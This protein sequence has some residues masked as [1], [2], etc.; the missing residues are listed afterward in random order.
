VVSTSIECPS[1]GSKE[2]NEQSRRKYECSFCHSIFTYVDPKE[3]NSIATNLQVSG[4]CST[5]GDTVKLRVCFFCK[6][7]ICPN[8]SKTIEDYDFF[9]CDNCRRDGD[10]KA[11]VLAQR[12]EKEIK[13]KIRDLQRTIHKIDSNI[14]EETAYDLEKAKMFIPIKY[15]AISAGISILLFIFLIVLFGSKTIIPGII[16]IIASIVSGF[17]LGIIKTRGNEKSL[18]Q[19]MHNLNKKSYNSKLNQLHAMLESN[20]NERLK[21]RNTLQDIIVLK[22]ISSDN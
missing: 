14:N 17:M 21:E 11:F 7:T 2:C 20:K 16:L 1:C 3:V 6:T 10:G 15:A 8:H 5:C 18:K 4:A 13:I 9:I 19:K 12:N 22:T